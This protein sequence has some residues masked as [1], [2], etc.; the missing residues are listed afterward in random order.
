[1]FHY[2]P[3]D[4][5][6]DAS[7]RT[8]QR[9]L[10]DTQEQ[11]LYKKAIELLVQSEERT[12][13]IASIFNNYTDQAQIQYYE[14]L[15]KSP[16]PA[17]LPEKLEDIETLF[18]LRHLHVFFSQLKILERR[19]IESQQT[20]RFEMVRNDLFLCH[21]YWDETVNWFI[22]VCI[23]KI[24]NEN[25]RQQ[26][27]DAT[28]EIFDL[29]ISHQELTALQQNNTL[30]APFLCRFLS[31]L[32]E[33]IDIARNTDTAFEAAELTLP[34]NPQIWPVAPKATPSANGWIS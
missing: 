2:T 21:H 14:L 34:R 31:V 18:Q 1:M 27:I 23:I 16:P 33:S 22:D 24:R 26:L 9:L 19:I 8:Y 15:E 4:F 20:K 12:Q 5:R 6:L 10:P 30:V 25:K 13:K 28:R 7:R 11:V 17:P 32:G 3:A 29:N